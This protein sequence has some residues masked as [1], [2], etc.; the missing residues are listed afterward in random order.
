MFLNF[1]QIYPQI[2]S[3][4]IFR[5]YSQIVLKFSSKP[6]L[7]YYKNFPIFSQILLS[8][9]FFEIIRTLYQYFQLSQIVSK[10]H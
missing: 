2:L 8:L 7:K 3:I 4:N 1:T 5:M 6:S 10:F 9:I